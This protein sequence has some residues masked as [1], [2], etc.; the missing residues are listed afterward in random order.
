M[1]DVAR[2]TYS[3]A[4]LTIADFCS[5]YHLDTVLLI[6]HSVLDPG[7]SVCFSFSFFIELDDVQDQVITG[8]LQPGSFLRPHIN[9]NAE[10]LGTHHCG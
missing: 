6:P 8:L 9:K 10:Q 1:Q 7:S 2:T 3:L 5:M 4:S